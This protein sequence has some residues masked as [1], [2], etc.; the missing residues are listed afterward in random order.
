LGTPIGLAT[1]KITGVYVDYSKD[2]PM[3]KMDRTTYI[4]YWNDT[5]VNSFGIYLKHT[6]LTTQVKKK[7]NEL[8]SPRYRL[9]MITNS[10]YRQ[11]VV[12]MIDDLFIVVY[13]VE[14]VTLFIGLL[15]IVNSLLTTVLTRT[16][17]IGLLKAIGGVNSQIRKMICIEGVLTGLIGSLIG[18][19]AGFILSMILVKYITRY[20]QGWTLRYFFPYL[21]T[22]KVWMIV[23]LSSLV[24][25]YYPAK[26]AMELPV[27]R[28]IAFE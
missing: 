12:K 17:E 4:T 10:E 27:S 13:A 8:F 5:L 11:A 25:S 21:A 28:A 15:G 20:S 9:L 7:I 19:L 14:F 6:D 16:R 24:A 18:I 23:F 1:F 22:V 3:I 2:R 26:K